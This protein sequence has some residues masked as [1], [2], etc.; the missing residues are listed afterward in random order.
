[1]LHVCTAHDPV[2]V[3]VLNDYAAVNGPNQP[4]APPGT[5]ID[6]IAFLGNFSDSEKCASA[7]L[8]HMPS[9]H[10]YTFYNEK[11]EAEYI[12]N[13]FCVTTRFFDW[14]PRYHIGGEVGRLWRGCEH[15]GDCAHNGQCNT[16]TQQCSCYPGWAGTAC[17]RLN[18]T[19]TR[20]NA[21][22]RASS[23]GA[24][25]TSWGGPMLKDGNGTYHMW[26]SQMLNHCG[27]S[28]WGGN[29]QVIHATSSTPL[30]P[31]TMKDVVFPSFSHEPD[32][33]VALDG[34]LVMVLTQ[35][36]P[37]EWPVCN[38]TDGHTP[39]SCIPFPATPDQD[40]TTLSTAT[41]YDG[42]WSAPKAVMKNTESDSNLSP[43]FT[44]GD[45]MIG[46]WRSFHNNVTELGY[47]RIHTVTASN[48][49]DPSTYE[50][51]IDVSGDLFNLGG[52][53]EDPFLYQDSRGVYHSL[54]HHMYGCM[55]CGGHAYSL[56]AKT[57]VYTGG[58][59]Y[60]DVLTFEDSVE[61]HLPTRE[62]PHLL[63]NDKGEPAYLSTGAVP[64]WNNDYGFT[65]VVPIGGVEQP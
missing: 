28:S 48:W 45:G 19:Q 30:G 8:S 22:Y 63:F 27:M 57:W 18:E 2:V 60:L 52:P 6:G 4:A 23:N 33:K 42:P 40:P 39:P 62:R 41:S 20:R 55:A 58:D 50:Y 25:L 1:M 37:N 35:R 38:C 5:S 34:T 51:N 64:G 3:G 24:N 46:L 13:C 12:S 31:Y 10:S 56:D 47:S 7:A 65:S 21:G 29:S 59:A 15:D 43:W 32:V 53:T 17:T 61:L 9:C 26:A 16:A 49:R 36:I 54:F 14:F 11:A 44:K